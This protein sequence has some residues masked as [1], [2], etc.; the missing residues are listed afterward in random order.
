MIPGN[1]HNYY[2]CIQIKSRAQYLPKIRF[3][4]KRLFMT[5]LL[6]S[7]LVTPFIF[8][9]AAKCQKTKKK[10]NTKIQM[11]W[12]GMKEFGMR[13]PWAWNA[14]VEIQIR[15]TISIACHF[16][17]AVR[18]TIFRGM[19]SAHP[20]LVAIHSCPAIKTS[21]APVIR[22][23][24]VSVLDLSLGRMIWCSD[25]WMFGQLA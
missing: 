24:F 22:N 13:L 17:I 8:H 5:A 2:L 3:R 18:L 7:L 21:S 20:N 14:L 15:V 23:Q 10:K 6:F 12:N 1:T 19:M 9:Q 16:E 11:E 4:S 25:G